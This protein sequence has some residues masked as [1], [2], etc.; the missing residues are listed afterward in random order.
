MMAN[1]QKTFGDTEILTKY[2]KSIQK[3]FVKEYDYDK[4]N[5]E[6]NVVDIANALLS[7]EK[8]NK[9]S[10][11]LNK[12]DLELVVAIIANEIELYCLNSKGKI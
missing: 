2:L 8:Y 3:Y 9:L 10:N 4:N 7:Q 11:V 6:Q 5:F 12:D 1:V